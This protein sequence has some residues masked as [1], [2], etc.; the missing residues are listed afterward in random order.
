VITF[1]AASLA[2]GGAATGCGPRIAGCAG[3]L[4]MRFTVRSDTGG[5]V[6]AAGGS[7]HAPTLRACLL[8]SAGPFDLRPGVPAA[9]DLSFD[10]ADDCATPVTIATMAVF[11]EGP[12]GVAGRQEFALRYTFAP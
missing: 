2:P 6:L 7:L 9:L 1:A 12:D 3:R 10:R 5:H 8:A 11:V 4:S